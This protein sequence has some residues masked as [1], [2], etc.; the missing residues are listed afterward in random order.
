MGGKNHSPWALRA[1]NAD[2]I[3]QFKDLAIVHG[4][5]FSLFNDLQAPFPEGGDHPI[6]ATPM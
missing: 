3:A 5:G 1:K 2:Y 4:Q 6:P